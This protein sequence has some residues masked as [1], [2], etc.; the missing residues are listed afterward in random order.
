MLIGFLSNLCAPTQYAT[1]VVRPGSTLPS[2]DL[3]RF[4]DELRGKIGSRLTW[5]K[6]RQSREDIECEALIVYQ[7]KNERQVVIKIEKLS[8][9]SSATIEHAL[10]RLRDCSH[11]PSSCA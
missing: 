1:F 4:S 5:L 6:Y 11:N 3:S 8:E 9:L 2:A 7:K 10:H